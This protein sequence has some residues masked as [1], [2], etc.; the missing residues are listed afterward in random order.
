MAEPASGRA[1]A[2]TGRP[3]MVA[4]GPLRDSSLR[5]L[6]EMV[7]HCLSAGAEGV[8]FGRNVWQHPRPEA[9]LAALTTLVH[10]ASTVEQAIEVAE[11]GQSV[12]VR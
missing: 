5:A 3:V 7:D 9:V 2:A 8:I 10:D 4:G 11:E 1:G 6:L 12:T